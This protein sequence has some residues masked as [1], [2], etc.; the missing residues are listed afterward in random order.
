MPVAAVAFPAPSS[1]GES[2]SPALLSAPGPA[3][4]ILDP[5]TQPLPPARLRV[6]LN[7]DLIKSQPPE[8][9]RAVSLRVPQPPSF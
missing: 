5:S 1:L 6:A 7:T 4:V 3:T 2:H 9:K 8:R